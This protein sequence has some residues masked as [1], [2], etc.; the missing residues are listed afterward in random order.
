MS[1]ARDHFSKLER[2]Q[3]KGMS[4]K[5]PNLTTDRNLYVHGIISARAPDWEITG[6][7]YLGKDS[8]KPKTLTT[9]G[10]IACRDGIQAIGRELRVFNDAKGYRHKLHGPTEPSG[11]ST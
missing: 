5:I 9:A 10:V 2:E 4:D 6:T 11:S 1:I 3:L 7:L 8:G